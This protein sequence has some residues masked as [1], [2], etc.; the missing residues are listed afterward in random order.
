MKVTPINSRANALSAKFD[1]IVAEASDIAIIAVKR[2]GSVV[3]LLNDNLKQGAALIG[4]LEIAKADIVSY[5]FS[6]E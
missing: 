2:D 4:A 6:E 1:E 5:Q 3:Y